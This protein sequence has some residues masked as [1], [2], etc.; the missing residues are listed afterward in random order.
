MKTIMTRILAAD[1]GGTKT[2]LQLAEVSPPQTT[3]MKQHSYD[4]GGFRSFTEV[5]DDFLAGSDIPR[6]GIDHACFAVAGPVARDRRS[7][8]VTNLPWQ[9]DAAALERSSAIPSVRII[10]DF[11]AVAHSISALPDDSFETL[12]QGEYSPNG[13]RLII[14]AGTGLGAAQL[15]R[16]DDRTIILPSEVGHCDFSPVDHI[17]RQLL[18]YLA[19]RMDHVSWETVLSGPGLVN[20]YRFLCSLDPGAENPSLK[21]VLDTRDDAAAISDFALRQQD[22][23]AGKALSLFVSLY[24]SAAGNLALVTL[25]YGGIYIAGGIAAKILPAMKNGTFMAALTSKSKMSTLLG[26]FPV[27]VVMN[28]EAGL[29]GARTAALVSRF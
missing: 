29:I 23:L 10:N 2:L 3:V 6:D 17:Q 28:P 13:N 27:R 7:A 18:E 5:L 21:T 11:E 8:N 9:L 1:I 14:G 16:D 22:P 15:Y 26:M 12:Q 20:T 19:A 25:P 4:S 24:G